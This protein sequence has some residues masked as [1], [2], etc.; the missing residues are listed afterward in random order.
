MKNKERQKINHKTYIIQEKFKK[1]KTNDTFIMIP[2][3]TS[4]LL[5]T[6]FHIL[7]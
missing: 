5:G 1:R 7:T 4:E 2:L 6:H 3:A